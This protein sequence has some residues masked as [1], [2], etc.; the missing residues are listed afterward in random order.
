MMN[1]ILDFW[2]REHSALLFVEINVYEPYR[3]ML[4]SKIN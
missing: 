3:M 1:I 4:I 2:W